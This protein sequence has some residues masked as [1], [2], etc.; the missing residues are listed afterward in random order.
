MSRYKV[1]VAQKQDAPKIAELVNSAYRGETSRQGWTTEADLLDGQRTD[2]ADIEEQLAKPSKQILVLENEKF[3]LG[4]VLIENLGEKLYL[5]MLTVS[6][7]LQNKGFGRILME[8]AEKEARQKNLTSIQMWVLSQRESL[9]NY[10]LRQDYK[11][12]GERRPFPRNDPRFGIPK[13]ESLEF[14]VLE[15]KLR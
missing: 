13:V 12:T 4:T 3:I 6:P 9:I 5:G 10:Y 8:A 7:G 15:K 1:R 14:V 11:L 2:P